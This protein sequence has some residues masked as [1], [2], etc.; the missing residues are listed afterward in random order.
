MILSVDSTIS[1]EGSGMDR[2]GSCTFEDDAFGCMFLRALT[3]E[4]RIRAAELY[5]EYVI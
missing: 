3:A 2:D 4:R 5:A 1:E